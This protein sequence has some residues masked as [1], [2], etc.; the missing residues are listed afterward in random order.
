VG[1][2][3]V[4]KV[5]GPR[6]LHDGVRA[7]AVKAIGS[8]R[9]SGASRCVGGRWLEMLLCVDGFGRGRGSQS[10]ANLDKREASTRAQGRGDERGTEGVRWG[11]LGLV[12]IVG[13]L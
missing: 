9:T 4:P 11:H 7:G 6:R 12:G 3:G 13:L 1:V 10:A 2:V 8:V 5:P